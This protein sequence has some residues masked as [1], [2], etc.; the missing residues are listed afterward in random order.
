MKYNKLFLLVFLFFTAPAWAFT[1][2][3]N[4]G[5]PG[6]DAVPMDAPLPPSPYMG[7]PL[8][9]LKGVVS[10][11]TLSQV[12]AVRQKDKFVPKFSGGITALDKKEIKLQGFMLP[13]D[14][15]EKQKRFILTAL[16]PS[17]SFCLPGGPDQ[18]VEVQAKTPVKYGF[19]PIV[20]NG[21]FVVLKDDEMGLYYRLTDAVVVSQ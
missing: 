6:K 8:P 21:K 11:K 18:L 16:P 13:L 17:C 14:M 10:W 20:V 4:K 3:T 9:E 15:G 2:A 1:G 19:E 7:K 12:E 5:L